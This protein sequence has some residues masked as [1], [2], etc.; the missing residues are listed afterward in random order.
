[1]DGGGGGYGVLMGFTRDRTMD[2]GG[3]GSTDHLPRS[4][5]NIILL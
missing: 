4:L 3:G 5:P 2:G 1:M